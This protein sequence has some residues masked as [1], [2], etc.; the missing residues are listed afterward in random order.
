MLNIIAKRR[1]NNISLILHQ[2]YCF[3]IVRTTGIEPARIAPMDP[4]SFTIKALEKTKNFLSDSANNTLEAAVIVKK[5]PLSI[6]GKGYLYV[7]GKGK[8]DNTTV[9]DVGIQAAKGIQPENTHVIVKESLSHARNA[10][11][12]FTIKN[13]KPCFFSRH[14]ME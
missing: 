8:S 6:L 14:R 7:Y 3:K 11:A 13:A 1:I 2:G 9:S 12:G 10:K 5:V 4:K